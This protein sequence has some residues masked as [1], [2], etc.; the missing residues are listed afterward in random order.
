VLFPIFL[1]L[2]AEIVPSRRG[3]WLAAF[4]IGEVVA[5]ALFYTWRPL[6]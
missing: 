3:R 1:V 2:A 6:V 4:G 5:A